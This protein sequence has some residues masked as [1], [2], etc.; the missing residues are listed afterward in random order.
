MLSLCFYWTYFLIL[1]WWPSSSNCLSLC[2]SF[3]CICHCLCICLFTFLVSHCL[4]HCCY[5]CLC[6]WLCHCLFHCLCHFVCHCLFRCICRFTEITSW[7][8]PGGRP[9]PTA[10]LSLCYSLS[11]SLILSFY[12]S[13]TLSL[14]LLLSLCFFW[15]HFLILSWWPSSSCCL[16]LKSVSSVTICLSFCCRISISWPENS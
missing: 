1:S 16:S 6:H 11:L 2:L 14:S 5:S 12:L 7:F 8:Y 9:P 15:T 3:Y 4:C 10:C 13:P